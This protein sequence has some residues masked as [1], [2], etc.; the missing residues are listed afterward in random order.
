MIVS[1]WARAKFRATVGVVVAVAIPFIGLIVWGLW[2]DCRQFEESL[3]SHAKHFRVKAELYNA[4][5]RVPITAEQVEMLG[6]DGINR[7]MG[8]NRKE[9]T[10]APR[11]P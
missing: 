1:K 4:T 3:A 6:I 8:E 9:A 11:N 5:H 10:N 2:L 7:L